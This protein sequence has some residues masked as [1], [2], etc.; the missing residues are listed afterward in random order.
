MRIAHVVRQY[1]PSV[2]GFEEVVRNLCKCQL[3]AG[4]KPYVVTLD[5][6]FK[7]LDQKLP[8][9]EIVDGVE[10]I[11]IPFFGS[12]RYPIAP[13]VLKYIHDA[14]LVH[15]HAIDFFYDYLAFTKFLHK[16]EMVASTHGGFFHTNYASVLKKVFFNTVTRV[17]ST[18]Y[19]K[20]IASSH[21]DGALFSQIIHSKKLIVIENGVDIHKLRVEGKTEFPPALLYFGRW[22]ENKGLLSTL[23]LFKL[24]SEQDTIN[25]W[26][27]IIAGRPYDLTR[28]DIRDYITNLSLVSRVKVVENPDTEALKQLSSEA[29]YFISMSQFEGFG[30]APIEAISAGLIPVLSAIPPFE[31]LIRNIDHG[32]IVDR[33]SSEA[34]ANIADHYNKRDFDMADRVSILRRYDWEVINRH[35]MDAYRIGM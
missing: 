4:H 17:S 6:Y 21:N 20:V 35:Y 31:N 30:I 8:C 3:L 14:D 11:R 24:L 32:I 12:T 9:R 27:L 22:S 15:V 26:R 19:N 23:K 29:T 25:E 7:A 18:F 16:K 10:V 33:V 34:A 1:Y 13:A 28:N 2:G 5:R